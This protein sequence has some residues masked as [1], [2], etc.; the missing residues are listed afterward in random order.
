M[1]FTPSIAI[2]MACLTAGCVTTVNVASASKNKP[3]V[4]YFL[5][6]VYLQ[7]TPALDGTIKVETIYLPDPQH[8]YSI[9]TA[10][11]LGNYTIDITRSE[12]GFLEQVT[13]NSDTTGVAKQLITS[14]TNLR[15]AEID[16]KAA[17]AKT[18]AT[19]AKT[20]LDKQT[21]AIATA[22][23]AQADALTAVQVAEAKLDLLKGLVGV[24]GVPTNFND[25]LLAARLAVEEAKVKYNAATRTASTTAANF[26]AANAPAAVDVKAY[27]P[28]VYYVDMGTSTVTLTEAFSQAKQTYVTWKLPVT[29]K[30]VA[31]VELRPASL[32]VRPAE[33]SRALVAKV[34]ADRPL[35]SAV[36]LEVRDSTGNVV[37]SLK[38]APL[39]SLQF[40]KLAVVIDFPPDAPAGDYRVTARLDQGQPGKPEQKDRTVLVRVEK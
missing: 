34:E 31:E 9:D 19:E 32:V 35:Q 14:E 20:A 2:I 4:R 36:L 15:A 33:K 11:F 21:S 13:F 26:A 16:A 24:T 39:I 22:D 28:A 8:E 5:P 30:V 6:K 10:S 7:V 37:T 38:P 29:D 18:E 25:Q 27:G 23:K 40:D 1:R 12:Q 17:K 3:G